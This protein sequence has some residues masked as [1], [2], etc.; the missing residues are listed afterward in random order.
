[1]ER[2]PTPPSLNDLRTKKADRAATHLRKALAAL[3]IWD[4]D[5]RADPA[6]GLPDSRLR[7]MLEY[8]FMDYRD[9]ERRLRE[10]VA[11]IDDLALALVRVAAEVERWQHADESDSAARSLR[12][13]H[14]MQTGDRGDPASNE[15]FAALAGLWKDATGHELSARLT[16]C[17]LRRPVTMP[18]AAPADPPLTR[19]GFPPIPGVST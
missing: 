11:G 2:G 17:A 1:M 8:E 15:F 9:P 10:I 19:T 5:E 4:D 18:R 12:E 6:D 16:A 13:V 14:L 3:G 7:E